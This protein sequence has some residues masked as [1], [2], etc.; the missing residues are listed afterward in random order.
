V[1]KPVA[2]SPA[3]TMAL[4]ASDSADVRQPPS[5][6]SSISAAVAVPNRETPLTAPLSAGDD[7]AEND[8]ILEVVIIS[9]NYDPAGAFYQR[10]GCCGS[11][12]LFL[13]IAGIIWPFSASYR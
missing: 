9:S 7:Q 1:E 10:C 13:R 8:G 6:N 12:E 5:G 2:L 4:D 11:I 3:H